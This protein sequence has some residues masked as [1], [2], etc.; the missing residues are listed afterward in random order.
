MVIQSTWLDYSNLNIII[1]TKAQL[2][3]EKWQKVNVSKQH[4]SLNL[5]I[6]ASKWK[7]LCSYI[8]LEPN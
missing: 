6:Y 3:F 5:F 8:V 7:T 1:E 4:C 2:Y